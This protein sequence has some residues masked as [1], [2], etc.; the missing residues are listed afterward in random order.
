[1]KNK[2]T[3]IEDYVLIHIKNRKDEEFSVFIDLDYLPKLIELNFSWH[4]WIDKVTGSPYARCTEYLG[5]IDGKP[6]YT[7]HCLH[8]LVYGSNKGDVIDHRNHNTLDDRKDNLRLITID[9]NLKSRKSKNRNN[10]S[11]YR[12]VSKVGDLWYV[13]LQVEGKN[14]CLKKFPLDQLDQAGLYASEMRNV[15]Y[16]KFAGNN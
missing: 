4:I 12:N 15:Y 7:T 6:K 14:T 9:K 10:T 11:G 3:I 8:E 5:K 16:G 1:M 2:Y 13:Q